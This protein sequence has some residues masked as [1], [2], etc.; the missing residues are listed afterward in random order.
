MI[1]LFCSLF[2]SPNTP[3]IDMRFLLNPKWKRYCELGFLDFAENSQIQLEPEGQSTNKTY[4]QY[5]P[6]SPFRTD[7]QCF[8]FFKGKNELRQ[9]PCS[10]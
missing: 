8:G 2:G 7:S 9:R 4:T 5:F 1:S 6:R 10:E 3:F